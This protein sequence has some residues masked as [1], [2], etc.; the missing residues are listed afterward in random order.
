MLP[1]EAL[2]ET[3]CRNTAGQTRKRPC[4][5]ILGLA[6]LGGKLYSHHRSQVLQPPG[7]KP[8]VSTQSCHQK[9]RADL[10]WTL[11]G[12]V[13]PLSLPY[14]ASLSPPSGLRSPLLAAAES[15]VAGDA[16]SGSESS[17]HITHS[18]ANAHTHI[19]PMPYVFRVFSSSS[20]FLKNKLDFG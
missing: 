14:H 15:A 6:L 17:R 1:G 16:G 3:D 18:P 9:W 4:P 8:L 7:Y 12:V 2:A 19:C 10:T 20:L 13:S 11:G 5:G